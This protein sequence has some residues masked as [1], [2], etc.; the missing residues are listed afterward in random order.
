MVE[1]CPDKTE[2]EG[3]IPSTRTRL[4]MPFLSTIDMENNK[5][6]TPWWRDGLI[7]FAKVSA[8]IAFP[9]IVASYIGKFLD[10]KYNTGNIIFFVSI[11]L[12]FIS[13]IYLIWKEM[14]IY[15]NKLGKEE[16]LN[17]K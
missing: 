17:N 6:N 9:I 4:F 13:T 2:V 5:N 8:Y 14:K 3:P 1:R 7:I 12:A 16:N 10:S 11:G 15:K